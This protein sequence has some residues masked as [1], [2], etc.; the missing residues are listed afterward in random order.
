MHFW[1]QISNRFPRKPNT[2]RAFFNATEPTIQQERE[3]KE[4]ESERMADCAI[5]GRRTKAKVADAVAGSVTLERIK[6]LCSSGGCRSE[7]GDGFQIKM[8]S[9]IY[10]TVVKEDYAAGRPLVASSLT[11]TA[12]ATP[13]KARRR[14]GPNLASWTP[15]TRS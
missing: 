7:A 2:Q 12:S 5:S 4:R 14:T 10:D 13:T 9:P 8:E 6:P 11:T 3:E 1:R 15:P